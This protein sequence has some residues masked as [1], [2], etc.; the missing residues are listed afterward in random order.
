MSPLVGASFYIGLYREIHLKRS[1]S[2]T[3]ALILTKFG[4]KYLEGIG[5]KVCSN[6][7]DSPFGGPDRHYN[8]G[9]FGYLKNIPLTNQWPE[10]IDILYE[11]ILGQGD[12]SLCK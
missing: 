6:Q 4:R 2:K 3:T 7:G 10:C 5:I 9:N 12:S 8:M 11:V 1:L